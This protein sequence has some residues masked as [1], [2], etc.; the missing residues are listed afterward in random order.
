MAS[1]SRC[2]SSSL[3]AGPQ[4]HGYITSS[5]IICSIGFLSVDMLSR[6][7]SGVYSTISLLCTSICKNGCKLIGHVSGAFR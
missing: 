7:V 2:G 6:E 1:L 3:S 5:S 4:L